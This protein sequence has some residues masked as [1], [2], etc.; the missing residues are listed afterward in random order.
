LSEAVVQNKRSVAFDAF[1]VALDARLKK[2]GKLKIYS[3]KIK[4]NVDLG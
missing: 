2:E 3:D 1:R 4:T